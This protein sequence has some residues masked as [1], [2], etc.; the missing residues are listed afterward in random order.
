MPNFFKSKIRLMVSSRDQ[1]G[2]AFEK[3]DQKLWMEIK[4]FEILNER[5]NIGY[6]NKNIV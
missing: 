2:S 3:M 5:K 4:S 6:E 1:K